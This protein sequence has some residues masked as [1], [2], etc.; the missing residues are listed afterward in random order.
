MLQ[1]TSLVTRA[2]EDPLDR[3][4]K[5]R[6]PP[7]LA[8]TSGAMLRPRLSGRPVDRASSGRFPIA[9]LEADEFFATLGRRPEQHQHAIA[10]LLHARL[11]V[12]AVGQTIDVVVR[13]QIVLLPARILLLPFGRRSGDHRWRQIGRVRAQQRRQALLEPR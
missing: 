8:E 13:R 2:G 6:E 1:P 11:P 10:I 5:S 4:P 12:N 3:L 9:D 7:S